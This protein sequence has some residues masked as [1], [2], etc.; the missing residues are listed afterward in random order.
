MEIRDYLTILGIVVGV[1]AN[2][3]ALLR[4]L[5]KKVDKDTLEKSVQGAR[6]DMQKGIEKLAELHQAVSDKVIEYG[7]RIKMLEKE[8][9]N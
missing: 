3:Y 4:Q 1:V 9:D 2:Y 5:D 6:G 8:R 7:V